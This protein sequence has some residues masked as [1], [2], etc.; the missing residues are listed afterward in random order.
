MCLRR[1]VMADRCS[2]SSNINQRIGAGVAVHSWHASKR[3]RVGGMQAAAPSLV[4][5]GLRQV[6]RD[7]LETIL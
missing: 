6:G 5:L 3:Q 7:E 2:A 4:D 1:V